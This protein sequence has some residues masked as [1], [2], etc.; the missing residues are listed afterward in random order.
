MSMAGRPSPSREKSDRIYYF[1]QDRSPSEAHLLGIRVKRGG[2]H[3]IWSTRGA[4]HR[5]R[6]SWA[7]AVN[8][9]FGW[10]GAPPRPLSK[11]ASCICTFNFQEA[12]CLHYGFE[13]MQIIARQFLMQ[14]RAVHCAA[15]YTGLELL[16]SLPR[17]FLQESLPRH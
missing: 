6:D 7:A 13:V 14:S 1:A 2:F 15:R 11:R 5:V 3:P 8:R 17:P 9:S 16:G 10:R 4:I 12:R